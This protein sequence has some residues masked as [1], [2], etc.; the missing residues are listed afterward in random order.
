MSQPQSN[1]DKMSA[2]AEMPPVPDPGYEPKTSSTTL[3]L[4]GPQLPVGLLVEGA[5]RRSIT[6]K[7]YTMAA[8]RQ[9]SQH[10]KKN[11]NPA[12]FA[13]CVLAEMIESVGPFGDFQSLSMNKRKMIVNQMYMADVLYAY[14]LLRIE[15]MGEQIAFDIE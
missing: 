9:L 13:S 7:P 14:I 11:R 1:P 2:A 10:K 12:A 6:F 3:E 4:W 15:A 8:E 5:F